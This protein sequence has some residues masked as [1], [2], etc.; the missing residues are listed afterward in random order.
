MCHG[1]DVYDWIRE[2]DVVSPSTRHWSVEVY[3]SRDPHQGTTVLW[4]IE[5]NVN[6]MFP[7]GI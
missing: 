6:T 7:C 4:Y 1:R 5:V 3:V 2:L